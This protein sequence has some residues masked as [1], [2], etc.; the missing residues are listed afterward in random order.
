[1]TKSNIYIY[2]L[3][4][5]LLLGVCRVIKPTGPLDG[6]LG[7]RFLVAFTAC[8]FTGAVKATLIGLLVSED[9]L[10]FIEKIT[11][12][13]VIPLPPLLM[14]LFSTIGFTRNSFKVMIYRP[15]LIIMPIGN[16]DTYL[17]H[18]IHITFKNYTGGR[19]GQAQNMV[20]DLILK[21]SRKIRNCG[22]LQNR[23]FFIYF[24]LK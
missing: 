6:I 17:I 18:T 3:F 13:L 5:L 1:M 19:L 8:L 24:I 15:E 9:S 21:R 20:L 23:I 16:N 11:L 10:S 22:Y 2:F 4:R 14:A 12:F 7:G